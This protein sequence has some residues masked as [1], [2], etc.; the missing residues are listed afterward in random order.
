MQ[1][2]SCPHALESLTCVVPT[3]KSARACGWR[4]MWNA[5]G[6]QGSPGDC[7]LPD[8][9][10]DILFSALR[11]EPAG[12]AVVG[13]MTTPLRC[14]IEAGRSF[15]GVRFRPGM[16]AAF[17]REAALLNDKIEPLESIWGRT[18]R[19]IFERLANSSTAEEMAEIMEG[20]LRPVEPPDPA[21][22]ALWRLP[23]TSVPLDRL[24]SDAG[25]SERHFRRACVERAGVSPKYLRRI[26]RFRRA[27][28]RIGATAANAA[29]PSW[30]HGR[31]RLLR[32]GAPDSG[33]SGVRGHDAWPFFTIP[34]RSSTVESNNDETRKSNRLH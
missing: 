30:A 21:Q 29:Q 32:P 7:I 34:R 31:L 26:L 9:C 13:L 3:R 16:A 4:A 14:D 11:G 5:I 2:R 20:A 6:Q 18:A 8:G 10:V 24:V 27:V 17:M 33:V 12:L 22:R 25:L 28:E 1:M 15:F 19:S 23:A